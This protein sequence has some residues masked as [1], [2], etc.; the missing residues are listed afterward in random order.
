[1]EGV[2]VDAVALLP[3]NESV[4]VVGGKP[5]GAG[6]DDRATEDA[7][8]AGA[9]LNLKT[10][11][12]RPFT[13]GHIAR[14]K[15]VAVSAD[16]S[17][18]FTVCSDKDPFVRV[19][20]VKAGKSLDPIPLPSEEDKI[21]TYEVVCFSRGRKLYVN[22][23]WCEVI[24]DLQQPDRVEQWYPHPE[25]HEHLTISPDGQRQAYTTLYGQVVIRNLSNREE[26]P[27]IFHLVP[28]GGDYQDWVLSD[29]T[30]MRDGTRLIVARWHLGDVSEVPRRTAEE[31]VSA[32][33][34]GLFLIDLVKKQV[35][36]LG[37]GHQARTLGFALH[38]S[39]EWIMTLGD[40]RPDRT[41]GIKP[42]EPV[43]EIRI[44]HFPTRSLAYRVHFQEGFLPHRIGFTPDGRKVVAVDYAG[45]VM[46]WEFAPTGEK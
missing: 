17:R 41:D 6:E 16:G 12:V 13:N 33:P 26:K 18:I 1:V 32:E 5:R 44:Y 30:F 23:Q 34:C 20:N 8:P 38:P 36:P 27:S 25:I 10:K 31:K 46:S 11:A 3:D 43:R 2:E 7:P 19:W 22:L 24:L 45:Q 29:L 9:I 40:S 35:T 39:E 28:L 4:V 37:M 15:S 14:I 42:S 21:G